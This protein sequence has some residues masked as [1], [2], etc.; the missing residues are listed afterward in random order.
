MSSHNESD[1]VRMFDTRASRMVSH[2]TG[3]AVAANKAV[4]GA[5]AFA[6]EAGIHQDGILKDQ[7]TYEIMTPETVGLS[8]SK[9]VLGK[10]SGRHAFRVRVKELGFELG[11]Q[12]LDHAFRRFKELADRKKTITDAD[13]QILAEEEISGAPEVYQLMDLQVV[14]GRPG[15]ST[16]TVRLRGP[17]GAESVAPAVGAGPIDAAF[18][19]IRRIIDTPNVLVDYGV[20]SVSPG[21]DAL[22]EVSVRIAS[23]ASGPDEPRIFGGHGADTDIVVASVK[24]YLAA[25]NRLLA[26]LAPS[27]TTVPDVALAVA[28]GAA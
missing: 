11:D 12:Q 24:A 20:H 8:Q 3:I 7:R 16:A 21:I 4:V 19:A 27:A 18:Q 13:L 6:H 22:G 9:L 14:C 1:V 25:L 15:M 23:K 26:A 17:D 10:H 28:A 2:F 5:N